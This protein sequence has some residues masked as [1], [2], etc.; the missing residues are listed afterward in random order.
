MIRWL[1]MAGVLVT[2]LAATA[3]PPAYPV[4]IRTDKRAYTGKDHLRVTLVNNNREAVLIAPFLPIER[5]EGDGT[6]TPVYKLRAVAQCPKEPPKKAGCVRIE[7]GAQ[8]T[9][10]DWNWNTG[11][12]DQCPPRRPGTRAFKGVHRITA[13]WCEGKAPP[14]GQPRVKLTTWE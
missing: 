12:E 2:S 7:P 1:V 10:V 13:R 11:G 3:T 8:L 9:L 4:V 5:S 6:W 14:A